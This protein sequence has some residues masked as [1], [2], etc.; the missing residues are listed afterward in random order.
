[1]LTCR[2]PEVRFLPGLGRPTAA[3]HAATNAIAL[4][5]ACIRLRARPGSYALEVVL[6]GIGGAQGTPAQVFLRVGH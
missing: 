2:A 4:D 3:V 1:L 6:R 5:A